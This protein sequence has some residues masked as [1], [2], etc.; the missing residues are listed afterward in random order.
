MSKAPPPPH[1]LPF[2]RVRPTRF[3]REEGTLCLRHKSDLP[4]C[5]KVTFDPARPT[6]SSQQARAQVGAYAVQRGITE[7]S[8]RQSGLPHTVQRSVP[9]ITMLVLQGYPERLNVIFGA[10]RQ[11]IRLASKGRHLPED[12]DPS[13]PHRWRQGIGGR[14]KSASSFTYRQM[15]TPTQPFGPISP[16][17]SILKA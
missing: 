10:S 11:N 13:R 12:R 1:P 6:P 15:H 17:E 3:V 9:P 5:T 7:K 4:T 16:Q 14:K 2:C 8:R